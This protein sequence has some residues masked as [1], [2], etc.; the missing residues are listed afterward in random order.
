MSAEP[1]GVVGE[2]AVEVAYATPGRQLIVK[3]RL[4]P[5]ATVAEA[6]EASALRGQFPEIEPQPVAG[7]FSKKVSL[8]HE[9]SSGDRVEIYRPLLADPKEARRQKVAQERASRKQHH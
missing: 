6:I 4:A 2:L 5:G 1:D 7:I 8:D 9:L 3:L